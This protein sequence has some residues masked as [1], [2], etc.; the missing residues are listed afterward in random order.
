MVTNC[1][2]AVAR[3]SVAVARWSVAVAKWSVAVAKWS[4]AV[5]KWS[6]AVA[7]WRVAVANCAGG[8]MSRFVGSGVQH[9]GRRWRKAPDARSGVVT[10]P[11]KTQGWKL[12]ESSTSAWN[13]PV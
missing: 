7:R 6:V 5:A 13:G 3:R 8:E 10:C 12:E 2:V 4:V 11:W 1:H 9:H